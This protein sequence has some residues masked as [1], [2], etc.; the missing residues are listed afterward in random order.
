MSNKTTM[1]DLKAFLD[2]FRVKRGQRGDPFTHV[3]KTSPDYPAGS[4]YIP[5]E[6]TENFLTY[7][8]NAIRK[9]FSPSIA[10]RPGAYGPLRVDFDFAASLDVGLKRQYDL[11]ILKKLV[12]YY[13]KEI[14][15]A[16]NPEDFTEDMLVCIVLEKEAPRSE[17]GKVK[18]GFHLHFPHFICDAKLQ[19]HYMRE[20]VTTQMV[21]DKIW[22]KAQFSTPIEK[23][24]D[25][26]MASK[27]W[28]MYGSM[29]YKS[30]ISSPY[31]YQRKQGGKKDPWASI[32]D[33]KQYGHAFD[34]E[35]NE[36]PIE[37]VFAEEM[38]GRTMSIR[39]YLPRFMTIRGY[40]E[41]T[42]L[43]DA[44]EK[45]I[46]AFGGRSRGTKRKRHINQKRSIEEVLA[47]LK[48]IKDGHIMEMLSD[49]R[50][51]SHDEWMDVGWTL[52]NVGQGHEE[53]LEMWIEF[54]QR[55]AKFKQGECEEL[56]NT[57]ELRDKTIGSLLMMAKNDNPTF[58]KQWKDTNVR[59]FLYRSLTEPKP[60]EF[61]VAMVVVSMYKDR[62]VCADAKKDIWYEFRDHRWHLMDD[63][64]SLKNLLVDEVI[65][66][67]YEFKAENATR[68]CGM[69]NDAR[70]KLEVQE[71]RILAIISKLKTVKFHEQVIK[72]CKLKM[73]DGTF[74][75]K[76]NENRMILTC[77]NGV[78]DL[79]LGIFRD[80]RPDDYSTFSTGIYY[81]EYN[82]NDDDVQDL[83]EF[84]VKVFP[85]ENRRKYFVDMATSC[86]QGGNVNK[87]FIISTGV[88]DNAKSVSYKL[89]ELTW[90]EYY[91][92]FPRELLIRG[93]GSSS[94]SARP[95]LS[96]VRGKRIMSTQ[97]IT[98]MDDFNIG[99]LKELTGNDSFYTRGLYEKGTEVAPQF[100]LWL[101][102]NNPPKI[103]GHDEATWS[104][105]RVLDHESKFVKPQDIERYPVPATLAEQIKMK[106][107]EADPQFMSTLEFL[108]PAL[109]WKLF[110]HFPTYKKYGLKE[111]KEVMTATDAYKADNDIYLEFIK[112]RIERENDEKLVT[113]S[114]IRLSDMYN[115][116]KEW[117]RENHPSYAKN[118]IGKATVKKELNRRL[119]VIRDEDKDKY[120]FGKLS[121]WWG[122]RL[123]QEDDKADEVQRMLQGQS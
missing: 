33:D 20:R 105:I 12:G 102:C 96:H 101:Q 22:S 79:E 122:Y 85:N 108:A 51:D 80:G 56:W 94:S 57:M 88:G 30:R 19:D 6:Y 113:E 114:F 90:G 87:R 45:K 10:E 40:T 50:A 74:L 75:K 11:T 7:Y 25:Q 21:E 77:E 5:A 38:A 110:R 65:E 99:V 59:N 37:E 63:N 14:R 76:M 15:A 117:Y 44:I 97:E 52:F 1:E 29:N 70:A 84:L 47:D 3:T 34:H 82:P 42:R 100:T 31:A 67:Y 27:P 78:L 26:N 120:G 23:I 111:P 2:Q 39:Y 123:I 72:M 8:S 118:M 4:F 71:T 24:I 93:R 43:S 115:E 86:L 64:L 107:F 35:L 66:R 9:G 61:D 112:E 49:D 95:E 73:H 17:E 68:Q 32:P 92:K 13:Q 91:G 55:S 89:M 28:M 41:A 106:R 104:R 18:D 109:L 83:E 53:A 16:V 98:H 48:I 116:F 103:P 36:I 46:I 119:G 121:R 60:T 69:D 54:S 58:Y 81:H 62:F